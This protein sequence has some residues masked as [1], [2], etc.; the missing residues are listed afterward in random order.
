[1][2]VNTTQGNTSILSIAPSERLVYC[3]NDSTANYASSC[4][5]TAPLSAGDVVRA[6][7]DSGA[8]V[9]SNKADFRIVKVSP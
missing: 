6:H 5:A 8:D 4:S 9:T 1:V 2:S 7:D 3:E